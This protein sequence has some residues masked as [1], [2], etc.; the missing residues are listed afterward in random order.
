MRES[1]VIRSGTVSNFSIS[2]IVSPFNFETRVFNDECGQEVP[3]VLLDM[4]ADRA[5]ALNEGTLTPAALL[6]DKRGYETF[7]HG[8]AAMA[9]ETAKETIE[10]FL[11][12]Y[13]RKVIYVPIGND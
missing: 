8:D 3:K 7:S 11:S 10:A 1:I 2:T 12:L 5:D 4:L 13:E 9:Y 6:S